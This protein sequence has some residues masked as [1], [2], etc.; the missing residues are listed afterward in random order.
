MN[1]TTRWFV[2]LVMLAAT[3]GSASPRRAGAQE[4]AADTVALEREAWRAAW[5]SLLLP[6]WGQR[7]QNRTTLANV[8]VGLE[9][10]FWGGVAGWNAYGG[11]R[12]EDSR[13]WAAL[14][15][16]VT[17]SGK[18]RRYFE[19]LAFY[20]DMVTYN[21]A[22]RSGLGD[23]DLVYPENEGYEWRWNSEADWRRYRR[24]RRLSRRAD[25]LATLA[26]GGVVAVRLVGAVS[27]L[28][29]GRKADHPR[30]GAGGAGRRPGAARQAVRPWWRIDSG[31]ATIGVRWEWHR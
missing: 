30:F 10:A 25:N 21:A 18:N 20:P 1:R 28:I 13:R 2:P 23:P 29:V 14:H 26:V 5:H 31:G 27:A 16:G 11:W 9:A 15:A 24:L 7:M 6:G 3:A 19:A 4:A 12:I 8:L 17:L 22:Q